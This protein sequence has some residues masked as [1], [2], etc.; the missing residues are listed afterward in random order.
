MR[1]GPKRDEVHFLVRCQVDTCSG[2][3]DDNCITYE[4]EYGWEGEG[5]G[6]LE[7]CELPVGQRHVVYKPGNTQH[8]FSV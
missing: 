6:G 8:G 3:D 5:V 4:L 7:E 2:D 1:S